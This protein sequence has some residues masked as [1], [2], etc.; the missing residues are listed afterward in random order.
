MHDLMFH[1]PRMILDGAEPMLVYESDHSL[2]LKAYNTTNRL[3]S[4]TPQEVTANDNNVR[5]K[6]K[7]G[8]KPKT[9]GFHPSDQNRSAC[10]F[11]QYFWFR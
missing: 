4:Y 2:H 8:W 3:K 6:L 11:I 5:A 9:N 10:N 7:H 1:D